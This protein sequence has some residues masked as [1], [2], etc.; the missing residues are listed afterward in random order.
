MVQLPSACFGPAF[1]LEDG[2]DNEPTLAGFFRRRIRNL[3]A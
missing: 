3:A 1:A 2:C